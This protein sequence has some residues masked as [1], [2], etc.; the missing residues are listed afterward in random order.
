MNGWL[1]KIFNKKGEFMYYTKN[2]VIELIGV[3]FTQYVNVQREAATNQKLGYLKSEVDA[4]VAKRKAKLEKSKDFPPKNVTVTLS[5][6]ERIQF[7]LLKQNLGATATSVFLLGME[8]L[9]NQKK[10]EASEI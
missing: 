5:K 2:Q 3:S 4:I 10:G 6:T 1:L 9:K 8:T 7:N